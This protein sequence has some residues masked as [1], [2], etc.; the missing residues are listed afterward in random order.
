MPSSRIFLSIVAF[1]AA[2]MAV[3]LLV[4]LGMVTP[5]ES[6][7]M[8]GGEMAYIVAIFALYAYFWVYFFRRQR[9]DKTVVD[10]RAALSVC[11]S[12]VGVTVALTLID[13]G[14]LVPLKLASQGFAVFVIATILPV[15]AWLGVF[16]S[17][18]H[19][20]NADRQAGAES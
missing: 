7:R 12:I 13:A 1:L 19:R 16:F 17:A 6:S 11:A 5:V 3:W 20:R 2:G 10:S 9:G 15:V 18:R 4:S 8:S 14:I